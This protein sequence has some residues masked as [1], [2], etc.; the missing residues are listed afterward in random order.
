MKNKSVTDASGVNLSSCDLGS[1]ILPSL[2]DGLQDAVFLLDRS[3]ILFYVNERAQRVAKAAYNVDVQVG[4]SMVYA[5]PEHRWNDLKIFFS[6]VFEGETVQY[7]IQSKDTGTWLHCYYFPLRNGSGDIVGC[8]A[9]VRDIT[10]EKKAR[11]IEQKRLELER[12]HHHARQLFEEFMRHSPLPG[13]ITDEKGIQCYMN[14]IYM[15]AYG[16]TEEDNGSSIFELFPHDLAT[17][18]YE[19]NLR[20]LR[21]GKAVETVEEAL[22]PDGSF[23]LLKIYKFPLLLNDVRMVAGWAVN[24]TEQLRL[25][26][27]LQQSVERYHFA[28]EATS[29]AIYDWNIATRTIMREK[30]FETLFGYPEKTFTLRY[31]L[32]RIHPD[33]VELFKESVFATLR[34]S[35]MD[36]WQVEYRLRGA[37]N[38]YYHI[39][40]K[41][42]VIRK[43]GK[44]VRV[45]GAI[46]D[47]THM[48]AL[49]ERLLTEERSRK[50][51]IVRSIIEAQEQ[52]RRNL[53]VELHDNVNQML[54]SCKLML[55]VACDGGEMTAVMTRKSYRALGDIITEIR[56]I[57]H[58]LNPSALEDIGLTDAVQQ[59]VDVINSTDKMQVAFTAYDCTEKSAIASNDRVAIFRIIQEQLNNILK[60]ARATKAGITIRKNGQQV[61]LLIEDN[62]VGFDVK[63]ARKGLGLRNIQ[64]RVD[65]Y[66]GS[67]KINSQPGKGTRMEINMKL[68][69]AD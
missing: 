69:I 54:A 26:D 13:W 5:F 36:R 19:N 50:Q 49:Q 65:Y 57:C 64:N 55:E 68:E 41:A 1:H 45:I 43:D 10:L 21:E 29:D 3:F 2:L 56:R 63:K 28:N 17:A 47:V 7:D 60:H 23:Q 48:K 22:L 33:D 20:V 18:Y 44:A 35:D 12:Q 61:L 4:S 42:Y 25:Q 37:N 66:H 8:C 6:R 30:Q 51:Q 67:L 53:S 38:R 34:N 16:L 40:D 9:R 58:D 27:E 52:E 32:A 46:Q 59:V 24:I 62:G 14:P 11:E 39:V 15:S 31:H